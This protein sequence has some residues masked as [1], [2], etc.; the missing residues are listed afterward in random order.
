MESLTSFF[1]P[2]FAPVRGRVL[3]AAAVTAA[4]VAAAAALDEDTAIDL[5]GQGAA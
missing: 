1:V 4:R 5:Q 3:L 2:V